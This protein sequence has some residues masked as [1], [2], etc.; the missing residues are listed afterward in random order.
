MTQ[1]VQSQ[2]QKKCSEHCDACDVLKSVHDMK[3]CTYLICSHFWF[4]WIC[5]PFLEFCL[6]A[7]LANNKEPSKTNKK[8]LARADAET[9]PSPGEGAAETNP[10][11]LAR[12]DAE[13]PNPPSSLICVNGKEVLKNIFQRDSEDPIKTTG[14]FSV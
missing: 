11:A 14:H 3:V 4:K 8:A 5:S 13:M 9:I 2:Q 6:A 10:D 1:G 7:R 12:A